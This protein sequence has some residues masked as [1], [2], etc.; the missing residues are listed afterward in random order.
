M[1]KLVKNCG[2]LYVKITVVCKDH[3]QKKAPRFSS[4]GPLLFVK[5]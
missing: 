5:Y 4:K 2:D 1:K 3:W